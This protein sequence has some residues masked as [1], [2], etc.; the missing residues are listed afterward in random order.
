MRML[1]LRMP[2]AEGPR[3]DLLHH[4]EGQIDIE[5]IADESAAPI[6]L[7]PW[8]QYD[9][10]LQG[11]ESSTGMKACTFKVEARDDLLW[12]EPPGDLGDD[13]RLLGIRAVSERGSSSPSAGLSSH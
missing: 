13:Y 11:G 7:C 2:C 3:A 12:V 4:L 5:D 1:T 8:H 6:I 10:S 9:F